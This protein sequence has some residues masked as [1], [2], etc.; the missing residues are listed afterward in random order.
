MK[1]AKRE[2]NNKKSKHSYATYMVLLVAGM[3]HLLILIL[4]SPFVEAFMSMMAEDSFSSSYVIIRTSDDSVLLKSSQLPHQI[5]PI[6]RD[7][8][9]DEFG[10]CFATVVGP[11]PREKKLFS[12]PHEEKSNNVAVFELTVHNIDES[13][14]RSENKGSYKIMTLRELSQLQYQIQPSISQHVLQLYLQHYHDSRL[15]RRLIR[16]SSGSNIDS[17]TLRPKPK[18]IFFDCDDC[19][20]FD[21][22]N[23][24]G[25]LTTKIEDHCKEAFNLPNGR[26]YQLY[27]E[28][29]TCLRGLMAEG[30]IDRDCPKSIDEFLHKVHDLPIHQLLV[31]D[32]KL[33][34]II[35]DIDPTIRKFVFTASVRHHA[36]RCLQALGIDD[37]F[38][39][40]IDVKD[41]NFET[42][43]STSSFHIAMKKADVVN[44]EECI[45]LDDSLTN[46]L[47]AS[48]VGWRSVLVGTTGRDCGKKITSEHAEIEIERIHDIEKI[49]PEIFMHKY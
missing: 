17:Y 29:G 20:Y 34:Q 49:L 15:K 48:Q 9:L 42:K 22:W 12:F 43:H 21:N 19:L 47:A 6:S 23:I 38:D 11:S 44:V 7:E 32:D 27:K 36:T 5:A 13:T 37:L 46:I 2:E 3:K 26:A 4:C 28:H 8:F 16:G 31:R 41:C 1:G 24:A 30:H 25:H 35:L 33:R 39:G 45:F 18:V 14:L 10:Q 40:I